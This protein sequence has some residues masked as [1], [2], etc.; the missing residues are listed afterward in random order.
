LIWDSSVTKVTASGMDDRVSIHCG[1]RDF[2]LRHHVPTGPGT[3]PAVWLM[4][5]GDNAA[6]AWNWSS[7]TSI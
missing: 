3:Y 2:H 1:F 5:T 4:R 7:L 6:G